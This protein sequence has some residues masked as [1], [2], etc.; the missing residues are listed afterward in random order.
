MRPC[1][2]ARAVLL[3]GPGLGLINSTR[4]QR[5]REKER[6]RERALRSSDGWAHLSAGG[7]AST[8]SV[9][10]AFPRRE[11]VVE[12]SNVGLIAASQDDGTTAES[13][14]PV[15]IHLASAL[16]GDD[17]GNSD[18]QLLRILQ[19]LPKVCLVPTLMWVPRGLSVRVGKLL[20]SLLWDLIG[21]IERHDET[22]LELKNLFFSTQKNI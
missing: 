21:S 3:Q 19:R 9:D 15:V 6:E 20:A 14:P 10:V 11:S 8:S 1:S 22:S 12:E 2:G 7:T 4:M 13:Q 17:G 18:E 5:E 16:A